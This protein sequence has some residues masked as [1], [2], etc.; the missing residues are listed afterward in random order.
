MY[1]Y[2][3]TINIEE[4]VHDQWLQWMKENHIPD[5]MGTG[6]F[7]GNRI[8]QV[9]ADDPQGITYSIQ[10]EVKDMETLQLYQEVYAPKLQKEHTERYEGKF[11]AFRTILRVEHEHEPE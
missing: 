9:M 6:L 1:I 11:V 4:D 5:V 7:L 2:N 8:M 10:Y 3:V